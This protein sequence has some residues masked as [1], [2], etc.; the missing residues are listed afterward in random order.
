M[1][2]GDKL[3]PS[4]MV[5]RKPRSWRVQGRREA[6]VGAETAVVNQGILRLPHDGRQH[7]AV[8]LGGVIQQIDAV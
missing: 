6:V 5:V 4:L 7:H 2:C 8:G 1:L 3:T